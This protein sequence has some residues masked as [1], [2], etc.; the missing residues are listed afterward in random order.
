MR[1][2]KTAVPESVRAAAKATR[3][4]L[5]DKPGIHDLVAAED[6]ADAAPFYFELRSTIAAL[7]AARE[8]AGLT[9]ADIAAKT[10]LVLET[11]SRLETGAATNPTWQTL[12]SYAVAVG[13][14]LSLSA[15]GP[16]TA[17]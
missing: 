1:T 6:L 13:C 11:L 4:K 5:A 7:K 8:Q 15:V 17:R 10:G 12:G 3:A 16:A 9:L 14:R 2:L